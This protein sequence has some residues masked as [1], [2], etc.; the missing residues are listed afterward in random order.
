MNFSFMKDFH[1]VGEKMAIKWTFGPS[2]NFGQHT[3]LGSGSESPKD[4]ALLLT[5]FLYCKK[6]MKIE[7]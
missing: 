2:A 1:Q 7:L 3:L 5:M 6:S 4:E